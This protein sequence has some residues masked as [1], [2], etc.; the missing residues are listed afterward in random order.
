MLAGWV[1]RDDRLDPALCERI[2]QARCIMGAIG[3]Q[4]AGQAQAR[5]EFSGAGEIVT[6]CRA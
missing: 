2:A 6:S 5:Q 1:W 3:E 4:P